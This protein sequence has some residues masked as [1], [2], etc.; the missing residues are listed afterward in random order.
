MTDFFRVVD[1]NQVRNRWFLGA[2]WGLHGKRIDPRIFTRGLPVELP[3]ELQMGLRHPGHPLDFTLADFDVPIVSDAMARVLVELAPDAVQT[4]QT[5]IQGASGQFHILNATRLVRGIDEVR[6]VI[7][8]WTAEDGRPEKTGKYRMISRLA[9]VPGLAPPTQI[10]RLEGWPLALIA[11]REMRR[12]IEREE[13]TGICF[14]A[15]E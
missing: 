13:F 6:S 1:D 14:S 2:P 4:I 15:L 11:T 3:G 7:R 8:Y 10:F 9:L 5:S 12:Q